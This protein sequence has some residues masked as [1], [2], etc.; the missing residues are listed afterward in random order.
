VRVVLTENRWTLFSFRKWSHG[1]ILRADRAFLGAPDEVLESLAMFL[2][3]ERQAARPV[4][5]AFGQE[6]ME[7]P[8]RL[9]KPLAGRSFREN[10]HCFHLG[11]IL[12]R[13]NRIFFAQSLEVKAGWGRRTGRIG[14]NIRLGSYDLERRVIRVHPVLDQPEVP[15]YVVEGVVY[16]E[17][18]HAAVGPKQANGR[19]VLHGPEFQ[20]RERLFPQG[21][22]AKAWLKEE[23]PR[24]LAR[25]GRRPGCDARRR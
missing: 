3:G 1:G 7:R 9:V 22:A 21:E 24:L 16:H 8:H 25:Q 2:Q 4:L 17:M 15:A 13:L 18:V 23:F 6:Q 10:G 20:R 14:R 19:R 11:E 5:K 12:S